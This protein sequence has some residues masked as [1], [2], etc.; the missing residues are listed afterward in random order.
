MRC[1]TLLFTCFAAIVLPAARAE[2]GVP[3]PCTGEAL[4][5][6]AELPPS[7]SFP[8]PSGEMRHVDLGYTIKHCFSGEWG[9]HLGDERYMPL[10][11][12][13]AQALAALAGLEKL[14]PAPGFWSSGSV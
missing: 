1:A 2:A 14:P 9:G 6:V 10:P 12:G 3:I 4:V 8:G 13:G 7:F 5:K 11:D